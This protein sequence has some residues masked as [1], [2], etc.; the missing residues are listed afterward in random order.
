MAKETQEEKAQRARAILRKLKRHRPDAHI[1]LRFSNPLELLV[2]TVL[3]AQAT[4]QRVN[5]VT[6]SLFERYRTAQDYA[7]A[8]EATLEQEIKSTGFFRQKAKSVIAIGQELVAR[9]GGKVPQTMAEM[10]ALPGVGRK[11]ANVV[12][13]NAMGVCSGI[14][15]D[16]HVQRVSRRTALSM[17]KTPEKIEAELMELLPGGAPPAKRDWVAFGTH[18]TLHGRYICIA[19]KP[20]CS[21]CLILDLCPQFEVRDVQ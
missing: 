10:V 14:V 4:D 19:G 11:T 15:V 3:A 12:L 16:T 13:G 2:A 17:E 20:C 7:T 9:H 8:D 18:Y 6:A 1:E 5:E 21:R